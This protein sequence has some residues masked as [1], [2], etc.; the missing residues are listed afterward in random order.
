MKRLPAGL[1]GIE[2]GVQCFGNSKAETPP[3]DHRGGRCWLY[4]Q[5]VMDREIELKR[6]WFGK[7]G[8]GVPRVKTY[9]DAKERGL[10]PESI[11][12][13]EDAATNVDADRKLSR[14]LV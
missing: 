8:N 9:L 10:T 4:T 1:A 11:I 3:S 2:F 6:I 12:F 5:D 13:A 14:F 7:D